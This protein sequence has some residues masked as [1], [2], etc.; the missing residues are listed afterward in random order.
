MAAVKSGVQKTMSSLTSL[1]KQSIL[2]ELGKVANV[3][4][5]TNSTATSSGGRTLRRPRMLV[6][7]IRRPSKIRT[8]FFNV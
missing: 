8:Y 2:G 3:V 5:S 4:Q 7:L 1:V 6:L